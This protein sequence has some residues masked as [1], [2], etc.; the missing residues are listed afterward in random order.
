MRLTRAIIKKVLI[1][2]LI[3]SFTFAQCIVHYKREACGGQHRNGKTNQVMSFKKCGGTA[4]CDKEKAATSLS[5]CQ[6]AALKACANKRYDITKLKVITA[7]WNGAAIQDAH[8]NSD[9]CLKYANRDKEFNR[10]S[11]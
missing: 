9:F 1:T 5:E 2:S 4:E 7:T 10:C 6:A 3:G 8:G 11:Q